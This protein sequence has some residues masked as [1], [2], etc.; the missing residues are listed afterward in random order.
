MD[1]NKRD[2][3][4]QNVEH[5]SG[6]GWKGLGRAKVGT[7]GSIVLLLVQ[8]FVLLSAFDDLVI[9]STSSSGTVTFTSI[10]SAPSLRFFLKCVFSV[11]LGAISF[12]IIDFEET[13]P[14]IGALV[15]CAAAPAL[16]AVFL[17]Y[18]GVLLIP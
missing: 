9:K 14:K 8:E 15:V 12:W 18:K 13:A 6:F 4:D 5:D 11:S 1:E 10:E 3:A 2:E 16:V 7:T 17:F